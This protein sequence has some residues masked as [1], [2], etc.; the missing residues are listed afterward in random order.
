MS[1]RVWF[2]LIIFLPLFGRNMFPLARDTDA[3]TL[4]SSL[5]DPQIVTTYIAAIMVAIALLI[6]LSALA[7]LTNPRFLL[8]VLFAIFAGFSI[9]VSNFPM[10]S[11]WRVS[12]VLVL[13]GWIAVVASTPVSSKSSEW[14]IT[15]L[16]YITLIMI[17]A[18]LM[19]A[20]LFPADVVYYDKLVEVT[21]FSS[22][23]L[24]A[25][26]PNSLGVMSAIVAALFYF[27]FALTNRLIFALI[28]VFA[29]TLCVLSYSRTGLLVLLFALMFVIYFITHNRAKL[30]LTLAFLFFGGTIFVGLVVL[31]PSLR[32]SVL[33]YATRGGMEGNIST[34][35]GRL[36]A[37]ELGLQIFLN[38][39]ILGT[40]YGVYPSGLEV[41]HF[42]NALI[43][44]AV[45]TGIF[46]FLLRFFLYLSI[47]AGLLSLNAQ[48]KRL[49]QNSRVAIADASIIFIGVVLYDMTSSGSTYFGWNLVALSVVL[50]TIYQ[51]KR[52]LRRS[53]A[54]FGPKT[55][56]VD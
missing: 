44:V 23:S 14:P 46:G 41:G 28:A 16:I 3:I 55:G 18:S 4:A 48:S 10:Y 38:S 29:A 21:R 26:A 13:L 45:T 9:A 42:H 25:L 17:F 52:L 12:E 15:N 5:L 34:I 36:E 32:D 27:R 54:S 43:E 50:I 20:L 11:A 6:R 53:T 47:I 8:L 31:D 33:F 40:G 1:L 56:V 51:Q 2:V 35:G 37:W 39:P 30:D 19:G 24:Y 49:P 7:I 22:S